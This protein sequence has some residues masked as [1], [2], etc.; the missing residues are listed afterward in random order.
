MT[1]NLDICQCGDSSLPRPAEVCMSESP[2]QRSR[3]REKNVPFFGKS[4]NHIGKSSSVSAVEK[5]TFTG[6]LNK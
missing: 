5:Q 4:E 6:N 1:S 3:S 2:N